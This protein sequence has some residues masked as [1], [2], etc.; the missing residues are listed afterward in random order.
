MATVNKLPSGA[1]RF[2]V[3]LGYDLAGR[4]IRRSTTWQ[5]EKDKHHG[6][7]Q[8]TIKQPESKDAPRTEHLVPAAASHH[9]EVI[10]KGIADAL[11]VVEHLL[12]GRQHEAVVEQV[13]SLQSLQ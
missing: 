6:E 1:Y 11:R 12:I 7:D 4:Q 5:P 9:R 10:K 2:T 3:S 13:E 8:Q